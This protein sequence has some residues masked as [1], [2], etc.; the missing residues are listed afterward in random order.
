MD[1]LAKF[2]L[3]NPAGH[4]S[5]SPILTLPLPILFKK[6]FIANL[7][8][9]NQPPQSMFPLSNPAW[10]VSMSSSILWF[11]IWWVRP[12]GWNGERGKGE[13]RGVQEGASLCC[14]QI[15]VSWVAQ[16]QGCTVPRLWCS[17]L[18][19]F[20]VAPFPGCAVPGLGCSQ[21]GKGDMGVRVGVV[22]GIA[23]L[24]CSLYVFKGRCRFAY[25]K[26]GSMILAGRIG[27]QASYQF[28]PFDWKEW[29]VSDGKNIKR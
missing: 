4:V 6:A 28:L 12:F 8:W 17:G 5:L 13:E 2:L 3:P 11:M 15:V 16:F 9:P 27:D 1:Y 10:H 24:C 7:T 23:S 18:R 22:Q 21:Q 29:L 25:I 14:S 19:S 20:R 26:H